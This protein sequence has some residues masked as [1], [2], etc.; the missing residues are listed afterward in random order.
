M[1]LAIA[2]F[3]ENPVRWEGSPSAED[4]RLILDRIK[5]AISQELAFFC[6]QQLR[7]KPQPQWQEAYAFRGTGSTHDR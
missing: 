2:R 3:V 4:K 6:P 1:T 5:A 7:E